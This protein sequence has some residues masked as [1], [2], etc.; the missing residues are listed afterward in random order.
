MV[1]NITRLPP[2]PRLSHLSQLPL[3]PRFRYGNPYRNRAPATTIPL[4]Q[5]PDIAA[6][7]HGARSGTADQVHGRVGVWQGW[8]AFRGRVQLGVHVMNTEVSVFWS[9]G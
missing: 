8:W 6:L 7:R 3:A 1:T 9:G 5:E 4:E 2:P